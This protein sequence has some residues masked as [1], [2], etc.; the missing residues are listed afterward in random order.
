MSTTSAEIPS[1]DASDAFPTINFAGELVALGPLRRELLPRYH[2]WNNDLDVSRTRGVGWPESFERTTAEFDRH[3]SADRAVA[4]TI[5]ARETWQPIGVCTLSDIDHRF[6]RATFGITIGESNF[7]GRGY[8]TEA[9]RLLLD[10]AF[11]GLGL[12]NVMLTCFA[13]NAG[14]RRAYEK[15]GFREFGRRRNASRHGGGTWDLVY[16][17]CLADEFESPMLARVLNPPE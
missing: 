17:E 6:G 8:G 12:S 5:Y 11:S 1:P 7:R 10:F 2:R 3:V 4:F 15:A 16:M 13:F 9:T 14:G